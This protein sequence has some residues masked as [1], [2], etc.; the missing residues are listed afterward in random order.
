MRA[1]FTAVL[2]A[3]SCF[4][5]L[6]CK[7]SANYA[8]SMLPQSAVTNLITDCL[9][10]ADEGAKKGKEFWRPTEP[11]P[12]AIAA[13]APQV[14]HLSIRDWATVVDIQTSGGFQH[15]GY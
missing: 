13:L 6:S 12:P 11:L 4:C 15:R 7:R 2:T 1:M 8:A 5:G 14:V 3:L 9:K 10:L